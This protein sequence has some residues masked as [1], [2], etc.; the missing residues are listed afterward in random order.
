VY[1]K[2]ARFRDYL[3]SYGRRRLGMLKLPWVSM[4]HYT[5]SVVTVLNLSLG[6]VVQASAT[7]ADLLRFSSFV[8]PDSIPLDLIIRGA[9][10]LGDTVASQLSGVEEDPLLLDEALELLTRYSLI[11]RNVEARSY[12]LHR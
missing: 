9:A 11:R 12:G 5:A 10:D 2:K 4:A 3:T 8:S 1:E 7:A 6:K